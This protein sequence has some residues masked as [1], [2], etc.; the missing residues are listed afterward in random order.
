MTTVAELPSG[1]ERELIRTSVRGFLEEHWPL[2]SMVAATKR[3]ANVEELR[4]I[5][6]K[7]AE[8]GLTCLGLNANDGG[9][10]EI[11]VVSE[12][13]GRR[14]APLPFFGAALANLVVDFTDDTVRDFL[15]KVQSGEA[16]VAYHF[17]SL[18]GNR[19]SASISYAG[20]AVKGGLRYVED[21]ACATHLICRTDDEWVMVDLSQ[22]QAEITSLAGLAYP[23]LSGIR[24]GC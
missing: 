21:L 10:S 15:E 2:D 16:I 1:E 24:R 3:A 9:M 12:E 18:E 7:F 4:T 8:L 22:A 6:R 5:Y 17:G 19:D 14:C 11:L 23:P 13:L 20:N